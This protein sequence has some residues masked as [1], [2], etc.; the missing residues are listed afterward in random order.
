MAFAL[1]QWQNV[2]ELSD[3][4]MTQALNL[5][6][7]ITNFLSFAEGLR[8]TGAVAEPHEFNETDRKFAIVL[9]ESSQK[10]R[11]AFSNNFDIPSALEVIQNLIALVYA[12]PAPNNGLIVSAARFVREIMSVLGFAPETL[13]LSEGG[14]DLLG[15]LA[16]NMAQSRQAARNN[17][18]ELLAE[19]KKVATALKVNLRQP[20]PTDEAEANNY[21]LVKA[22]DEHV[23]KALGDLDKI[24][25]EILPSA[26]IKLEDQGDGS[27]TF[28]VGE[29]ETE[30]ERKKKQIQAAHQKA[31]AQAQREKA[32][33]QP[34]EQKLIEHPREVLKRENKYSQFDADGMP[35]HDAD[36][37]EL[38]KSQKNKIKKWYKIEEEKFNK[39]QAK[40][41][42][43]PAPETK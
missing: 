30:E 38:S 34:K 36:G 28:K 17:L 20:R 43:S 13:Q 22:L 40:L 18:K 6:N 4:L 14:N 1:V 21:D 11:D 27:V 42:A 3:E 35:T 31:A 8:A 23:K 29:P 19:T 2:L 41:A 10:V 33:A 5:D 9:E 37:K 26:G 32:K 25:D 15:P 7:R 12:K 24:R 39:Q 16:Q